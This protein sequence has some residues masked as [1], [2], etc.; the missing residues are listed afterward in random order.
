MSNFLR[1]GEGKDLSLTPGQSIAISTITG[2]VTADVIAGT[3]KGTNLLN[4]STSGGTFGPYASGAVIRV[5]AG[6]GANVDYDIGTAPVN[7]YDQ[8]AKYAFD[9]TGQAVGLVDPATGG[10]IRIS[11]PFTL[12]QLLAAVA[13]GYVGNAFVSDVGNG[14]VWVSDGTRARAL[15]GELVLYKS[16]SIVN[17]ATTTPRTIGIEVPLPMG[18]W[19]DGDILEVEIDLYKSGTTDSS[20]CQ[21]SIGNTGVVGT[22]LGNAVISMASGG[23]RRAFGTFRFKRNSS[24]SVTLLNGP[25]GQDGIVA[26]SDR[27][28]TTATVADMDTAQRYLQITN[29]MTAGGSDVVSIDVAIVKLITG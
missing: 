26:S 8:N 19:K 16:T 25:N 21:V 15:N 10:I 24:T 2:T 9:T 13:Q 18:I 7:S 11:K 23:N 20:N 14:T 17:F 3:A 27:A 22:Q 1:S 4:A 29:A 28:A 5:V 12:V 6:E